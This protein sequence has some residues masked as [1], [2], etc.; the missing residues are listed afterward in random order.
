MKNIKEALRMRLA[1]VLAA[2]LMAGS[3][4]TGVYA[5]EEDDILL[6]VDEA[7]IEEPINEEPINA[8]QACDDISSE[9]IPEEQACDDISSEDI[10]EETGDPE[11]ITMSVEEPDQEEVVRTGTNAEKCIGTNGVGSPVLGYRFDPNLST[12]ENKLHDTP[13]SGSYVYYG[14]YEYALSSE[15]SEVRPVKYRVLDPRTTRF[16]GNDNT[17]MMLLDC[18][19]ILCQ[20]KFYTDCTSEGCNKWANSPIRTYLNGNEFY[21]NTNIFTALE[22]NTIAVSKIATHHLGSYG[23]NVAVPMHG[24]TAAN[25]QVYTALEGDHVFLLDAEDLSNTAYGYTN[26]TQGKNRD[27]I[28]PGLSDYHGDYWTRSAQHVSDN[29]AYR[30]GY[31]C[32]NVEQPVTNY[33]LS[34]L[35]N[36]KQTNDSCGVS[37][38]FNVDLS[39]VVFSSPVASET[40]SHKLTLLDSNF[41]LSVNEG[42]V[43]KGDDAYTVNVRYTLSYGSNGNTPTQLSYVVTNGTWSNTG[44]WSADAEVLQ[45]GKVIIDDGTIVNGTGSFS[46]AGTGL[47]GVWGSG[48]HVYLVAEAVNTGYDTDYAGAPVEVKAVAADAEDVTVTYDGGGHGIRVSVAAPQNGVSVKYGETA[49]SCNLIVSPTVT[50]ANEDSPKTVYYEASASGYLT[51]KGLATVTVNRAPLTV[52]A[53]DHTITYGDAPANNGLEYSG[54]VN[55]ET[56]SVLRGVNYTY[57]YSR[58]NDVG[59]YEIRPADTITADN[60]AITP[61]SGKLTV[62]EREAVLSWGNTSL[63]YNGQIQAPTATVTNLYPGD[64]CVVTVSGG[65]I[66]VG[67]NYMATAG[68]LSNTNYKLP[69]DVTRSFQIVAADPVVE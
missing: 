47:S 35:L 5:A 44:G 8:E 54:F 61:Q 32:G 15:T 56:E 50:N 25:F 24:P 17:T 48:Y 14:K 26:D 52:K 62:T 45:Y 34:G 10:Q 38:A 21:G 36:V 43:E 69:S 53:K 41:V 64:S 58:G 13:W 19:T 57:T 49:G 67:S 68:G 65:M 6:S 27:K 37:P 42:A 20:E 63:T 22:K 4:P 16:S 31:V 46:I 39:K 2:V 23:N 66:D 12:S 30:A 1:I 51:M 29:I 7:E 9:D 18:D 55:G 40:A 60:Y 28:A 33:D 11:D 3:I 59:E